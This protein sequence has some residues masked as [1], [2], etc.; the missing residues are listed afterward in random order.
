MTVSRHDPQAP[1]TRIDQHGRS[2]SCDVPSDQSRLHVQT[3]AADRRIP[4]GE[5]DHRDEPTPDMNRA[6]VLIGRSS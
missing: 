4:A 2:A 5:P 1:W 3:Q 6:L